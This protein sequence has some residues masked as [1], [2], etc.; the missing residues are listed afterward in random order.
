MEDSQN[1]GHKPELF[2]EFD[3]AKDNSGFFLDN[4]DF[5]KFEKEGGWY[6][7]YGNYYNSDGQPAPIPDN[8]EDYES[9]SD[10]EEDT[11]KDI[12]PVDP[13]KKIEAEIEVMVDDYDEHYDDNEENYA[14]Y[15]KLFE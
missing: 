8:D 9:I 2:E 3:V 11:N 13:L 7:K 15:E 6:D 10:D 12:T 14:D 4:G 1:P 5:Y